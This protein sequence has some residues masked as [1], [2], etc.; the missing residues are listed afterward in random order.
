MATKSTLKI[1]YEK[2]N[3]K[4]ESRNYN[5]N[6]ASSDEDVVAAAGVING[7]QSKTVLGLYRTDTKEIV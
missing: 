2:G 4:T 1:K 5:V 3:E 6:P 7:L